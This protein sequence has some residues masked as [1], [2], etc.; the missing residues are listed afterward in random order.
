MNPLREYIR[1]MLNEASD[2]WKDIAN[3]TI[4]RFNGKI[5]DEVSDFIEVQFPEEQMAKFAERLL[6]RDLK[7][8]MVNVTRDKNFL[9]LQSGTSWRGRQPTHLRESLLSEAARGLTD[10]RKRGYYVKVDDRGD[11]F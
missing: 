9:E 11:S 7:H 1:E 10:F 3:E 2:S 8:R 5:I 6:R 4:A